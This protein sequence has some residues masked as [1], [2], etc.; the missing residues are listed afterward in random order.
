MISRNFTKRALA[1]AGGHTPPRALYY[2]NGVVN[3]LEV[4]AFVRKRGFGS[5]R[6]VDT[7]QEVFDAVA[8]EV[9]HRPILYLEF[10]VAKGASMRYWSRLATNPASVLHGF[11]SFEGLPEDWT[12]DRPAGHF[13]TGGE[14]PAIDDGRV[15]FFKG[16]FDDTLPGYDPPEHEVLVV[17]C[18]ADL[19]SSTVTVLNKIEPWLKVGS[20]IY[21]DEFNH[22]ADELR[23]FGEFLDR[24]GARFELYAAAHDLAHVAFRC[25]APPARAA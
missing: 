7:K 6:A 8:G 14:P 19:Y 16:W 10:G 5:Y 17:N 3:Y 24:T 2:L 11:D 22:R 20:F 21:F 4:G 15:S 1:S 18:D 25:V 13:S 12:L 23:A 9:G